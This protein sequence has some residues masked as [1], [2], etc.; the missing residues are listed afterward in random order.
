MGVYDSFMSRCAKCG[1]K[2]EIQ[3]K[4]FDSVCA[5]F[6]KGDRVYLSEAPPNFEIDDRHECFYCKYINTVVVKDSIF[7]G[8]KK[9]GD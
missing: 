9:I 2:I 4:E 7:K 1:T 3:V 8:F 6:R 5:V